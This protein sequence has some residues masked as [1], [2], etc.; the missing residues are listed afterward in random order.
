MSILFISSTN[1]QNEVWD[2]PLNELMSNGTLVYR[3]LGRRGV[4]FVVVIDCA[5]G[6][7]R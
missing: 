1:V 4:D 5:K 6:K 2:C 3:G 7:G